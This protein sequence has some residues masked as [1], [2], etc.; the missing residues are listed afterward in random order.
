MIEIKCDTT[1]YCGL[2]NG[3]VNTRKLGMCHYRKIIAST[4]LFFCYIRRGLKCRQ[5]VDGMASRDVLRIIVWRRL[6][7]MSRKID[8]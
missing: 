3:I 8:L 4:D 2:L 5:N 6:R 7:E 1:Y